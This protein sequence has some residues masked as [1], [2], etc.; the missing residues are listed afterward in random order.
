MLLHEEFVRE[1]FKKSAKAQGRGDSTV[2]AALWAQ[3][4]FRVL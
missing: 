4:A 1:Q 3:S 2:F